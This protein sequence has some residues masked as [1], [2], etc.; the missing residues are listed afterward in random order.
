MGRLERRFDADRPG[1]RDSVLGLIIADYLAVCSGGGESPRQLALMFVPRLIQNPS[2]HATVILRLAL[3]GPRVVFGLWR[4]LLIAKHAIDL[5]GPVEI[6]PGLILP[7][8]VSIVIGR[9][10]RIGRNVRILNGVTIG[11]RPGRA[12][13]GS[14]ACPDIRD[15]ATIWAQSIVVGPITVGENATLGA[16]SWVDRD[17]A[18]GEVIRSRLQ[19]AG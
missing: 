16:R 11:A 19:P 12:P 15:G 1:A 3:A 4:T 10:T 7:H 18:P 17:V 14:R 5:E 8:P 6:G 2:L 9:G 13:V